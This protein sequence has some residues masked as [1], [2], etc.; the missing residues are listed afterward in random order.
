MNKFSFPSLFSA[1]CLRFL[2]LWVYVC[3]FSLFKM[4]T[5]HSAKELHSVPKFKKAV[6]CLM[7]QNIVCVR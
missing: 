4:D 7:A 2:L 5:K 1:T 6:M 3:V